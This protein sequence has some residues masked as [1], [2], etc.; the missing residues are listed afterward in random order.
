[1]EKDDSLL[2]IRLRKEEITFLRSLGEET[3]PGERGSPSDQ[4]EIADIQRKIE[5]RPSGTKNRVSRGIP[6]H[7][8]AL[9]IPQST[10]ILPELR[11]CRKTQLLAKK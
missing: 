1:M 8:E 3:S 6:L 5:E 11:L 10:M 7:T 9:D 2:S 4:N